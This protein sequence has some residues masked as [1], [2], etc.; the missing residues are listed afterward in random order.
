MT[1]PRIAAKQDLT[2]PPPG[3]GRAI[4]VETKCLGARHPHAWHRFRSDAAYQALRYDGEDVPP[5]SALDVASRGG[6]IDLSRVIHCG[7]FSKTLAPGLRIGWI[8]AARGVVRKLVLTKQAADLHTP[9]INQMVMHH[10]AERVYDAQVTKIRAAYRDRR[11]RMLAALER[12]MPAGVTWTRPQGGMFV[13]VTLPE[14]MDGAGLLA[15]A[16]EDGVAFVPGHAFHADGTGGNSLR[17]SFSLADGERIDEGIRRLGTL[18]AGAA[19]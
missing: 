4:R 6:D 8:C 5:L 2:V 1:T 11:D 3:I 9:T 7:S 13:W 18:V 17:L 14:G 19:A 12:H 16:V 10:V 15:R